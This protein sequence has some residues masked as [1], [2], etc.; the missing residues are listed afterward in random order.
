[1]RI[2]KYKQTNYFMSA[3]ILISLSGMWVGG[4]AGKIIASSGY[5]DT[6]LNQL[7]SATM[8]G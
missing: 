6:N 5:C 1:M 3:V 4:G 2:K 8:N 7:I